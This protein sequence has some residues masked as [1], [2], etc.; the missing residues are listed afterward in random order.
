MRA[1]DHAHCRRVAAAPQDPNPAVFRTIARVTAAIVQSAGMRVRSHGL[2]TRFHDW[3]VASAGM[4]LP[5]RL[6]TSAAQCPAA[7]VDR[8]QRAAPYMDFEACLLEHGRTLDVGVP[9]R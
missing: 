1:A 4:G 8:A 2:W 3:S 6:G 5:T 9:D 7:L